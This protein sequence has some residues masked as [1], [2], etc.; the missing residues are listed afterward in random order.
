MQAI[1]SLARD[2]TDTVRQGRHVPG[3]LLCSSGMHLLTPFSL[4]PIFFFE[5]CIFS[6]CGYKF[7][8]SYPGLLQDVQMP[9]DQINAPEGWPWGLL[10]KCIFVQK[11]L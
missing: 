1:T 2:W 10:L 3:E 4:T 6:V 11:V 5:G 8:I 7:I 9:I